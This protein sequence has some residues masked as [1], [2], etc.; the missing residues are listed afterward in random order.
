MAK[1]LLTSYAFTPGA[2]NAGTVTVPGT[3][4]LN[5]FLLITNVTAG[6]VIYQFNAP[7]KGAALSVAGGDTT[8]TLEFSTAAMSSG[9]SLQIFADST[10]GASANTVLSGSGAPASGTGSDGDFYV[11]TTNTRIYGPKASGAW[12][13]GTSLVGP[14]GATGSAGAAGST[15]ATGAAGAAA[16]VSVGSTTTGEAG[17]S[18][19]VSNTGTSSAAVLAFTIP[20]GDTGATGSTGPSGVASATAPITY[21]SGTQTVAISAATTSAAG[22]MSSA[23]KTKLDGVATGATANSSDAT[24]LAR[25]NHT[26]TQAFSTL[27]AA[28][29]EVGIACS[30]E[31]TNLTT[32]TAKVTFRMPLAMS[33]TAV[34]IN[35]NTAPTGSALVVNV[36]QGG[37]SVFST[38]PQIDAGTKTSVGSGTTAVI[39]TS[40][41]TSDAEITI[42][43]DQIG[44]TIAGKGLKV[45]LIG[46]RA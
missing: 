22:S 26:G 27:T 35:V 21:N 43:L 31:T 4:A 10:T 5:Q 36:L 34:R 42:N 19:T 37:S 17:T 15:G 9:D 29:I 44:S 12:G 23:D 20:R 41:L 46:T 33:L 3:Y 8:L 1:T 6:V 16:T 39:S 2:A 18:A 28:P 25:A 14:A 13:S 30:D 45:W 24:L 38:K 11:D 40:A 7:A 32:G